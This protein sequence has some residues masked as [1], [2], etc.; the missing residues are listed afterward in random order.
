MKCLDSRASATALPLVT[1]RLKEADFL[2]PAQRAKL[3]A[4]ILS[5]TP[6]ARPG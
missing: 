3:A 5:Q 2:T 4:P 6:P 1:Q